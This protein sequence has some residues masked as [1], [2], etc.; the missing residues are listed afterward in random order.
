MFTK[1]KSAIV[2][3]KNL[4]T[5]IAE[6][7]M[8]VEKEFVGKS[9]AEKR[10]IVV[11]RI[12]DLVD[13]PWWADT[14]LDLDGK[15]IGYM[16][17]KVCDA[18]NILTDGD[19]SDV[20]INSA[21]LGIVADAPAGLINQA[22]AAV[23]AKATK[24]QTVDERLEELYKLYGVQAEA[25]EA[26]RAEDDDIGAALDVPPIPQDDK[27]DRC[28]AIVGVAEGGANFDVV[29]GKPVLKEKSKNDKGG[30]TKYGITQTTLTGAYA[31]GVVGHCDIVKLTKD[32]AKHIYRTMYCDPYGWLDLPFEACLCLLDATINHGLGG[33]AWIAQ[34]TCNLISASW[35]GHT[36]TLGMDGKWGPKTKEGVWRIVYQGPDVF[37]REFL[38]FR[39]DYY[40]RIIAR[41][42][43]QAV[44]K[45]G[46]YNRLKMLAKECG[47][48]SPV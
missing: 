20:A 47:V 25:E 48:A 33:T 12:D 41:D 37:A 6:Y 29:N 10:A 35:Q 2:W 31:K 34:R 4:R 14:L 8:E 38:L 16:V 17:D 28:I 30:L 36:E 19:F 9:G 1:I 46:W 43:S 22:H 21:K 32:E 7:V 13:L 42:S 45:N 26:I 44:F 11:K 23:A 3:L 40:D 39:R 18:L 24:Q 27:W 5:I 15:F